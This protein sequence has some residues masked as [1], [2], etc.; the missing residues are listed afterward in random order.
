LLFDK[1]NA[2][3]ELR[4]I[5]K[6]FGATPVLDRVSLSVPAGQTTVLLGHSGAGKSTTMQLWQSLRNPEILSDD[7]II[8]RLQNGELPLDIALVMARGALVAAGG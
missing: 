5:S 8:L 2:M 1:G 6:A 4:S 7:R 3:F